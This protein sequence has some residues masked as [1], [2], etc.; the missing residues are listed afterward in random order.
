M[1]G[2]QTRIVKGFDASLGQFPHQV[3][4]RTHRDRLHFCGG[5]VIASRWILT[6]AHCSTFFPPREIYVVVGSIRL[7]Q[8]GTMYNID[9]VKNH[10]E[11]S[12]QTG[13]RNDIALL[14]TTKHIEF[15]EHVKP[16][17]LAKQNTLGN[18]AVIVSGWGSVAVSFDTQHFKLF[19]HLTAN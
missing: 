13:F 4:L 18:V 9:K 19:K 10:P 12:S 3:S 17:A 11:Y 6:A 5:A 14:H 8:N 2:N 7:D 15:N 1:L 16:I